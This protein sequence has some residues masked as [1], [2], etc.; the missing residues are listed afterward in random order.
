MCLCVFSGVC[1]LVV[2]QVCCVSGFSDVVLMVDFVV[3]VARNL[4]LSVAAVVLF[5]PILSNKKLFLI[6][7]VANRLNQVYFTN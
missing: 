5:F 2:F 1:A 7:R 4:F 3:N 6:F